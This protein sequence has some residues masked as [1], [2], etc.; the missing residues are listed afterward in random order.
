M[1]EEVAAS[2]ARGS[3]ASSLGIG[4]EYLK[5]RT[6]LSSGHQICPNFCINNMFGLILE[7]IGLSGTIDMD[8]LVE[9]PSIRVLTLTNNSFGGPMP[10]VQKLSMLR[11]IFL[12]NNIFS[13]VIRDDAFEGMSWLRIVYLKNNKF[14]GGIPGSL[15]A[16]S[17]LF[18]LEMQNNGFEGV[19][20]DFE[21]KGLK[22]NFANNTLSSPIPPGFRNQ[23]PSIFADDEGENPTVEQVRKR[24]SEIMTIISAEAGNVGNKANESSK[25]GS[26]D[27]SSNPLKGQSM[28]NKSHQ[29]YYVTYVSKAFF[30]QDDDVAWW[31][32]SGATVYVCKDRCWFK[33]NESLNDGSI[34]TW[35]MSQQPL[36]MDVV[37]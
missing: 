32:D 2:G 24:A 33:T 30:V 36:C 1:P 4:R 16:L 9:L 23:D 26:G 17:E 13:G 28:F 21:Q 6:T 20:P 37:V 7:N 8:T 29:I 10:D 18:Y 19:I 5:I 11:G 35:E 25:K 34:L 31:V 22:V 14:T 12:S 3:L 15:T 27:G